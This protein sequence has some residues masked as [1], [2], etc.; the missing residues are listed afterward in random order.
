MLV[1]A[2]PS[3]YV[4]EALVEIRPIVTRNDD[5]NLDTARQIDA[6]TEVV[7]ARSQRVAEQALYRRRDG[8]FDPAPWNTDTGRFDQGAD[9]PEA[10]G[11]DDDEEALAFDDTDDEVRAAMRQVSVTMKGDTTIL[12]FSATAG[13]GQKARDLAQSTALAYLDFRRTSA[14][15]ANQDY[16]MRLLAREARLIDELDDLADVFGVNPEAGVPPGYAGISKA[17]EL[18]AIGTRLANLEALTVDPGVVLTDA[19]VP[20]GRQGLPFLA[21]PLTGAL[22][23][24]VAALAGVFVI[25]RTDDRLRGGRLELGALGVPMLG[26][27][28][29]A[30]QSGS[31]ESRLYPV[32]TS[33]GDAY[34]R[35]HGTLVFNLDTEDKSSVLVA[36]VKKAW[37]ASSVAANVAATAARAGRR[38]LVVGADLRNAQLAGHFGLPQSGAGLSDVIVGTAGLGASIIDVDEVEN[39]FYLGAGTKLDRPA[40]IVQSEAFARL[41]AAVQADYDLVVVEVPP[42][43]KVADAVDI[44]GFCDGSIVVAD[45]RSDARGDIAETVG[46]LR[47]VGGEVV[48]VVVAENN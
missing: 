41:M 15:S 17:E 46:Q 43:L 29:V 4:S 21:G 3:A 24:L 42:V 36:G 33:A 28:P 14:E 18:A 11:F 13:G 26:A 2:R 10:A 34:R 40:D 5:P 32:N 7:V 19:V 8:N 35:L 30:R 48:G 37:P 6:A 20:S 47:S 23:G 27:A 38:T 12:S 25:D 45:R 1:L 31:S 16:R 22:L 39:L 9:D 44:A